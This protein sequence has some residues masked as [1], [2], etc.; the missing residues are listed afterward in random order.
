MHLAYSDQDLLSRIQRDSNGRAYDL[1]LLQSQTT[2][3]LTTPEWRR[4]IARSWYV[5]PWHLSRYLTFFQRPVPGGHRPAHIYGSRRPP[6]LSQRS[7]VNRSTTS[8]PARSSPGSYGMSP[9]HYRS[10]T[11]TSYRARTPHPSSRP[12]AGSSEQGL[13]SPSLT[14][15]VEMYHRPAT[16]NS[17]VPPMSSIGSFYY[18]YSEGFEKD[19]LSLAETEVPLCPIPQRAPSLSRPM[20]LRAEEKGNLDE[21]GDGNEDEKHKSRIGPISEEGLGHENAPGLEQHAGAHNAIPLANRQAETA[22]PDVEM[23]HPRADNTGNS[24]SIV[25]AQRQTTKHQDVQQ[26]MVGSKATNIEDEK[27]VEPSDESDTSRVPDVSQNRNGLPSFGCSALGTTVLSPGKRCR[28]SKTTRARV[29]DSTNI[30]RVNRGSYSSLG[31]LRNTLDPNL[32]EFASLLTS[33][34]RLAKS[35]VSKRVTSRSSSEETKQLSGHASRAQADEALNAILYDPLE[36]SPTPKGSEATEEFE[37]PFHKRHKRNVAASRISTTNI[38]LPLSDNLV[39]EDFKESPVTSTDAPFPLAYQLEVKKS[40]PQLMKALPPLPA[41]A[42]SY[43]DD[44]CP[45]KEITKPSKEPHLERESE[46]TYDF[47]ENYETPGNSTHHS[48]PK[49]KLRVK[50]L[51]STPVPCRDGPNISLSEQRLTTDNTGSPAQRKLKIK[52]SRNA[53]IPTYTGKKDTVL[54]SPALKQCNSLADLDHCAQKDIFTNRSRLQH[55][56]SETSAELQEDGRTRLGGLDIVQ[57]AAQIHAEHPVPAKTN[58]DA[59]RSPPSS[60]TGIHRAR[61]MVLAYGQDEHH[62]LR[63]KLSFLRLRIGADQDKHEP[64]QGGTLFPFGIRG[65]PDSSPALS[66]ETDLKKHQP[67]AALLRSSNAKRRIRR[68]AKGAK[69]A[70][71]RAMRKTLD[72]STRLAT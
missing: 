72:R 25:K 2:G 4:L 37:R 35:P 6:P 45:V 18:D 5:F 55:T 70:M 30:A 26:P 49:L 54:R 52:I 24:Q 48:P 60:R 38:T 27:Y 23:G 21:T 29:N 53:A 17:H 56:Y 39:S 57:T 58:I 15:I 43:G 10:R 63:Q 65:G 20:V 36:V 59:Q 19:S 14:S 64:N 66:P 40:I 33:F 28:R 8:L 22:D 68:W 31:R 67:T 12:L 51:P 13:R 69:S 41:E 46:N 71:R 34:D 62:R 47:K 7:E 61:S 32:F 50:P 1:R 16:A 9:S 42:E 3:Q 11:P 44:G